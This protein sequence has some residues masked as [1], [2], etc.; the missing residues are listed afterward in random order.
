[1]SPDSWGPFHLSWSGTR[2]VGRFA[3]LDEAGFDAHV[4]TTRRG[5]DAAA[6][7]WDKSHAAKVAGELTSLEEIAYCDQVHGAEV[8]AVSAGGFAGKADGLVTNAPGVGLMGF[9]ADCP[10]VLAA[11]AVAGAVGM[12]HASWR[13]TVRGVSARM[14]R[15][16]CEL[17]QSA[18]EDIVACVAPSAGVCCYEVGRDVFD[19]AVEHMGEPGQR[20]FL[21]RRGGLHFDLWGA[22]MHWLREAGVSKDNIHIAPVCTI[23]TNDLFCSY[24]AEGESA[25]RFIAVIGM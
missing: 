17:Y 15:R 1:M 24:R 14:V 3:P 20:Y 4:V 2:V 25:G 9:S 5:V 11:D 19:A 7:G 10:L 21:R 18:A 12:A 22:N 23:C 6:M 8:L 16:M 13:G